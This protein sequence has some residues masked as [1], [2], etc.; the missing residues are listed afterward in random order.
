MASFPGSLLAICRPE[1]VGLPLIHGQLGVHVPDLRMRTNR[2]FVL[3]IFS[4][5]LGFFLL[6]GAYW[7]AS[8]G[9]LHAFHTLEA[10]SLSFS[11]CFSKTY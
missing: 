2:V 6:T 11:N 4:L 8:H 9:N 7:Q 3:I 10:V 1:P 5:D